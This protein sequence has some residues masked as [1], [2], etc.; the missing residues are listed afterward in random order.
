MADGGAGYASGPMLFY[1]KGDEEWAFSGEGRRFSRAGG[2]DAK[3][4]NTVQ[5]GSIQVQ[6]VAEKGD[7]PQELGDK[8]IV[9]LREYTPLHIA[10]GNVAEQRVGG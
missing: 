9:A 2:G 8:I 6:V 10:V 1:T 7:N 5:I 3:E 4:G